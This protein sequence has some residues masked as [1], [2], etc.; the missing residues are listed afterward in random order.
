MINIFSNYSD[1]KIKNMLK[2]ESVMNKKRGKNT[3]GEIWHVG[4]DKLNRVNELKGK[5]VD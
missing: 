2:Q 3:E 4:R 5:L 1:Y